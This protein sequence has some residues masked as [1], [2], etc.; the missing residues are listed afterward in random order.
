M[1]VNK[2]PSESAFVSASVNLRRKGVRVL[3]RKCR[4]CGMGSEMGLARKSGKVGDAENGKL[5]NV[6]G[7][8]TG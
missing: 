6:A 4:A 3:G 8:L 1:I 5:K 2:K 7:V